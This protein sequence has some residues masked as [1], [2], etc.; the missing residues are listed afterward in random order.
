MADASRAMS[1]AVPGSSVLRMTMARGSVGIAGDVAHGGPH[2]RVVPL[3]V[4][5]E[6]TH[7]DDDQLGAPDG[8]AVPGEAESASPEALR[9]QLV[10]ARLVHRQLARVQARH[11]RGIHIQ[12]PTSFPRWPGML[13]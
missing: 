7:A 9:D 12:A 8:P 11:A 10:Q 3:L 1:A 2:G 13:P 6:R 5:V 4:Q